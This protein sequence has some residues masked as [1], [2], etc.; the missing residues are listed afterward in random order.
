M[1]IQKRRV[2]V[3]TGQQIPLNYQGE[4][5]AT[6]ILF[7]VPEEL[8]DNT[9]TLLHQRAKDA[10]PYPVPLTAE[11]GGLLWSV[12]AVDAAVQGYGK[13]QLVCTGDS[14]E[15]LKTKTYATFTRESLGMPGEAPAV[16]QP[17]LSRLEK[18][19]AA[20]E[21]AAQEASACVEEIKKQYDGYYAPT[22]EVSQELRQDAYVLVTQPEADDDGTEVESLRRVSLDT[23]FADINQE[24]ADLKYEKIKFTSI[25]VKPSLAE[26]GELVGTAEIA[27]ALSKEPVSQTVGGTGVDASVRSVTTQIGT[28]GYI[29]KTVSFTVT[30]TDERGATASATATLYCYNGVYWGVLE[31]G[32]ELDSAAILGLTR[33]LRKD[34]TLTFT[35]EAGD[36]QRLAFALPA[37]Y[38]TPVFSVGGFEGGFTKAATIDFTNASGYTGSYD[39]WLSDNVGLGSTTVKVT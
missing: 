36:T 38:G 7:R 35:A 14:G 30:A 3:T 24:I 34:R 9:W 22:V 10:E 18:Y 23:L 5:L 6:E 11:D 12:T 37:G 39:V 25:S 21:S 31:D 32:A 15:I 33:V 16:V 17:Y 28:D 8:Q 20:A 19:A 4:N 2:V 27:W 26:I 13:A 1:A 29:S